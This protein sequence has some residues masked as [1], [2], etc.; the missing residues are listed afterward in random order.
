MSATALPLLRRFERALDGR[1]P[2]TPLVVGQV[3]EP[4]VD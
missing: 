3:S 1:G 4:P 2:N